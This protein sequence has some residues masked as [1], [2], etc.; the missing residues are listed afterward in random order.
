VGGGYVELGQKHLVQGNSI[1]QMALAYTHSHPPYPPGHPHLV[2]ASCWFAPRCVWA[3][4]IKSTHTHCWHNPWLQNKLRCTR[5]RPENGG[6]F[7]LF[8]QYARLYR[9]LCQLRW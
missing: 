5:S 2:L 1:Q 3:I 8:S 9:L 7:V 6:F 4:G